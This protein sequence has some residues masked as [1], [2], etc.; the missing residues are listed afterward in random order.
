MGWVVC[1]FG[2]CGL[3]FS[4]PAVSLRRSYCSLRVIL[5]AFLIAN[6]WPLATGIVLVRQMSR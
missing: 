4:G 1:L 2:V 3:V 6:D 5:D